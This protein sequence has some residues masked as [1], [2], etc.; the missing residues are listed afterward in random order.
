[1]F[2]FLARGSRQKNQ[3]P[4]LYPYVIQK[5]PAIVVSA[6]W[7]IK[8][9]RMRLAALTIARDITIALQDAE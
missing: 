6:D 3:P 2:Q 7:N 8:A 1:M 5:T 9:H 4:Q